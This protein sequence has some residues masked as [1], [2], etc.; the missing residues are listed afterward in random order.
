[1]QALEFYNKTHAL[2]AQAERT[3][4]GHPLL[5][6]LADATTKQQ[7]AY[8]LLFGANTVLF[9]PDVDFCSGDGEEPCNYPWGPGGMQCYAADYDHANPMRNEWCVPY[10]PH[11]LPPHTTV[12]AD[13]G[14]WGKLV[15][16]NLQTPA[17]HDQIRTKYSHDVDL[18]HLVR[19]QDLDGLPAQQLVN[20]VTLDH[21]GYQPDLGMHIYQEQTIYH[22]VEIGRVWPGYVYFGVP[23]D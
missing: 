11:D 18:Q 16:S 1:M 8:N 19:H 23:G 17:G 22:A 2:E 6:P 9:F 14:L 10:N 21:L 20:Q 3:S 15:W 12:D 5:L 4:W 13:H 7:Q